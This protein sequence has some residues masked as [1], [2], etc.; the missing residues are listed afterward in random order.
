MAWSQENCIS[1]S[2]DSVLS[3][4]LQSLFPGGLGPAEPYLRCQK[5]VTYF[6]QTASQGGLGKN[7]L[8][9]CKIKQK[10]P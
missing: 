9:G 3:A 10:S 1:A 7:L 2:V 6:E 4:A 8:V 5:A